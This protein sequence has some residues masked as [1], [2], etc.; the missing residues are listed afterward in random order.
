MLFFPGYTLA[1]ALFPKRDNLGSMQ[2]AALSFGL[3]IAIA[4]LIGIIL[5]Y[6]PWGIRLY[7][8]LIALTAFTLTTSVVALY[9]RHRLPDFEWPN[10]SFNLSLAFWKRQRFVGK[11]S[12]I[13]LIV[14]ILGVAGTLGYV[15]ATPMVGER[16]T[17]F[18]ILG[19]GGKGEN[20]P[21]EIVVGEQ[22]KV[23]VG[24]I[25]REHETMRYQVEIT[26]EGII[27]SEIGPVVLAHEGQWE[28]EVSFTLAKVG[29]KQK[30]DFILYKEG[31]RHSQLHLWIDV[32]R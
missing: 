27:D 3:S 19:S 21:K 20:Y 15:I 13:I 29:D 4:A 25:N 10:I 26:I 5:N 18:Y 12:F 24:I 7:P 16:F 23:I 6:T 9:Q 32:I 28:Q 2:R 14:A 11:I 30:V 1:A 8:V 31:Q 22:A 17:E